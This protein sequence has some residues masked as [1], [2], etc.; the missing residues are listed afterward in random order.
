MAVP[1]GK[2]SFGV[3]DRF[4]QQGKAQLRAFLLAAE[5]GV[6]ITPVWN[7]SHREHTIV[8]SAPES[9]RRAA[10]EAVR[11]LGW[12][13]PYF[14]DAD[15]INLATVDRFLESCDFYTIDVA[16]AIGRPAE[17]EAIDAF[18][19]R[20]PELTRPVE[21]A[22]LEEPLASSPETLRRIASLYLFPVQEAGRIYRHIEARKGRGGFLTEVSMDETGRP[23]GPLEL[24][25]ILA[26]L[27]DEGIPVATIAP[28]F[29]GRFNKGVDY[30]GDVV[31]F[32]REFLADLAVIRHAVSQ[33]GLPPALKLSVHSGSDKFSIYPAIRRALERFDAG[34][35]LKT[36]GTT[37]LE[38]LIGL[39]EAGGAG[40][41]L[42]KE[43]YSGAYAQREALCAPYAAVIA[44]DPARLPDPAEVTGW[45]AEQFVS[46]LRHDPANPAFNPHL[47]QLLHVGYKI[48][49]KM[50]ERY[51]D[52]LRDCEETI[53][54]N[55]TANLYERHMRPLFLDGGRV[56][57]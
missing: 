6:A 33:Y 3:G 48:A 42:A 24:L 49:A 55:V 22:G 28:K 34:V 19:Q 50:G 25:V 21:V 52:L 12:D 4:A 31:Q 47:R 29:T 35:H 16:D 13:K 37:W 43:I 17:P 57:S 54:R 7:K 14:V 36:A 32:E 51:L 56:V 40:L 30:E 45:S 26:A 8:G 53:A 44:I 9:A 27:A 39:A 1:L 5:Q 38:E 11:A 18:L 10:D 20:H 2:Y 23:Q 46:A 41:A 15:H